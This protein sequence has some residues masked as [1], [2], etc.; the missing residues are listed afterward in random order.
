MVASLQYIDE[1]CS[2]STIRFAKKCHWAMLIITYFQNQDNQGLK[3]FKRS[4]KN[5]SSKDQSIKAFNFD[6][7]F[8]SRV[9][10]Y[11]EAIFES[12]CID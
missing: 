6:G 11:I 10:N 3:V 8:G 7:S 4:D 5:G 12:K 1:G 2:N 9:Q